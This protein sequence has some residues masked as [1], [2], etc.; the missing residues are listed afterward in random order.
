MNE[1]ETEIIEPTGTED[2]VKAVLNI[3]EDFA[4]EKE[5]LEGTQRAI[6][7]ILEDF[8]EEKSPLEEMRRA[9][10]N[11]L[12][13]FAAEKERLEA[14]QRAMLNL[15]DDFHS[16]RT[17]AE[18]GN[19]AKSEFLANMSHELRTPLSAIIGF[20]TVL[21]GQMYGP[22]TEA[23]R[24]YV[25]Y[26]S[27]SGHHL[28]SLINEILNLSK[29]ESG[30]MALELGIFPLQEVLVTSL[31]M[32]REKALKHRIHLSYALGGG[33]D[34]DICADQRKLKQI[35]FNL[36]SNAVKFTPDGGSITVQA[37][38]IADAQRSTPTVEISVTDTG[39]GI[40]QENMGKLFQPF[41]HI[42]STYT[43]Q[44]EGT[45]L[46]LALTRRLVELHGGQ[47]WAR[48][49]YGRGSQFTFVIPI[50]PR[51]ELA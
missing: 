44:Y 22:L 4:G 27:D 10:L 3:L 50:A 25:K 6:F 20:S 48:S 29:V 47:I 12:E 40:K 42:E 35:M 19:Q 23:Q 7:N 45:G 9:M 43:K 21:Q 49:E 5:R 24:E 1:H 31:T 36:L 15:L 30:T 16:E 8:A 32:V 46:G 38:R 39:I 51:E 11:I 17:R 2:A 28:L 14:T 37:R 34:I 13:D 18:A 33:A 41:S 26:I